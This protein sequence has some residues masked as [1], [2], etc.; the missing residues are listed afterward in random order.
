MIL[1]A[2]LN[3]GD[4]NPV[5]FIIHSVLFS[6]A[7]THQVGLE[8]CGVSIGLGLA[9]AGFGDSLLAAALTLPGPSHELDAFLVSWRQ[10]LRAELS[11][12]ASGQLSQKF[13]SLAARVPDSFPQSTHLLLYAKPTTSDLDLSIHQSQQPDIA[14]LAGICQ[15]RFGWGFANGGISVKFHNILWD[16]MCIRM[17]C[18]SDNPILHLL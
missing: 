9:R 12:N 3:G 10:E 13:P 6:D 17:L 2:L 8:N 11:T 18:V 4:Y 5:C 14:R 1:I 15:R 7:K 16:G